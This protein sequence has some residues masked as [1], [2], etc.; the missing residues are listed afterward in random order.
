MAVSTKQLVDGFFKKKTSFSA[1]VHTEGIKCGPTPSYSYKGRKSSLLAAVQ[2][3]FASPQN[4]RDACMGFNKVL[5]S[6]LSEHVLI[7]GIN[8]EK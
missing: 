1:T 6:D 2:K 8:V 7:P 3:P 5:N 4:F